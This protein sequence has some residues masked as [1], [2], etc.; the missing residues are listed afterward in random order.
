MDSPNS[1]E[2]VVTD[3]LAGEIWLVCEDIPTYEVS[4]FGRIRNTRMGIPR[5]PPINR[6]HGYRYITV[7]NPTSKK[8][9]THY[10]HR[11]V[12]KAFLVRP[13]GKTEVNHI[14]GDKTNCDAT[15]LEWV[16]HKQNIA[17][18]IHVLKRHGS[19]HLART[20]RGESHHKSKLNWEKVRAIRQAYHVDK[21]TLKKLAD[22]YGVSVTSIHKIVTGKCWVPVNKQ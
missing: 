12:A 5:V 19:I 14:D 8:G 4:Q 21:V 11:L 6:H 13:E 10:L 15:N 7:W 22:A 1:S 17:H 18:A 20:Y 16:T 2:V 3:D 9:I